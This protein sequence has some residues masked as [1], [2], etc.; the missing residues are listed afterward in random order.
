LTEDEI[1]PYM[2]GIKIITRQERPDRAE[3]QYKAFVKNNLQLKKPLTDSEVTAHIK[4]DKEIGFL[5]QRLWQLRDLFDR[6]RAA[7]LPGLRRRT[8]IQKAA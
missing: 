4:R 5:G 2:K 6:S 1:V 3:Q 7:G 8:K